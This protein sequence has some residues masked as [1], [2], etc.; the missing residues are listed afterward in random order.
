MLE[1]LYALLGKLRQG[2]RTVIIIKGNSISIESGKYAVSDSLN[3]TT[4]HLVKEV[5]DDYLHQEA[6]KI[7][8]KH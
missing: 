6:L 8:T 5:V 3:D 2:K 7:A 4:L 1:L